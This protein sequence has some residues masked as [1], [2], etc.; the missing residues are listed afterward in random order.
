[1]RYDGAT[2][3]PTSADV[4]NAQG[5]II[6]FDDLINPTLSQSYL[7]VARAAS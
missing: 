6:A 1:V 2:N 5:S 7:S 4:S 3:P